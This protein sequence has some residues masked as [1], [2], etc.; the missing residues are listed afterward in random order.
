MGS[1][2]SS[3]RA[4]RDPK[5]DSGRKPG[6]KDRKKAASASNKGKK[7]RKESILVLCAHSDDQ[8][9]GLGGTLAKFA[10][11]GKRIIVVIFSYGEKSHPWLKRKVT[12]KMRVHESHEAAKI[13]GI[14]KTIFLGIQEGRFQQ[15]ISDKNIHN[16]INSMIKKYRPKRIFTHAGDDPMPDHAAMNRFVLELC[17]EIKY[18]GDVYTFDV[19]TPLKIKERNMPKL[20]ID[21]TDTF[22]KKIKA[23]KAFESQWASMIALLWSVYWRAIRNGFK[24]HCRFAEVFQKI[25]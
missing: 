11:E 6:S 9:F 18:D 21:I 15:E 14:D 19:W 13:I 7:S 17:D 1:V 23:L 16:R 20:Y 2:Y 22:R 10:E 25:R 12:V 5:S 3:G 24:A 8:V 4:K